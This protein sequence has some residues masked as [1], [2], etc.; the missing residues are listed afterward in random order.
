MHI[1]TGP[2][3]GQRCVIKENDGTTINLL[4]SDDPGAG[5]EFV[6]ERPETEM[7]SPNFWDP[8]GDHSLYC[9][10]DGEIALFLQNIYFSGGGGMEVACVNGAP[11]DGV[12]I[13][14]CVVD[15]SGAL[16]GHIFSSPGV[17]RIGPLYYDLSGADPVTDS[18]PLGLSVNVDPLIGGAFVYHNNV[19]D[20]MWSVLPFTMMW[21]CYGLLECYASRILSLSLMES[22][23]TGHA[24]GRSLGHTEE[25][26]PYFW[27]QDI[28][29]E[30]G[31]SAMSG[32][33]FGAALDLYNS[34][35]DMYKT[36]C[37]YSAVGI[38]A[39]HSLITM[40]GVSGANN[41]AAGVHADCHSTI[42]QPPGY[43][44]NTVSGNSGTVELSKDGVL[45]VSKWANLGAAPVSDPE[46]V[47]KELI[48]PNFNW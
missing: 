26:P 7:S 10:A 27:S 43:A 5:A 2:M 31:G 28:A 47:A 34:A 18:E 23:L 44:L 9:Y 22:R 39:I 36:V 4:W 32:P 3:A 30:L 8:E 42:L 25:F 37:D 13:S 12:N 17:F 46:V 33:W 1:K 14:H 29:V 16:F 19:T 35:L 21:D 15:G 11:F 41:V 45:E 40:A 38:R 20:V 48:P 24:G 6:I